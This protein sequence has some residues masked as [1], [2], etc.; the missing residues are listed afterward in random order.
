MRTRL[1][2]RGNSPVLVLLATFA[3][4]G[5]IKLVWTLT[6]MTYEWL[7]E[8]TGD[9]VLAWVGCGLGTFLFLACICGVAIQ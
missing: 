9:P 4:L 1:S 8:F 6:N 5:F 7:L 2:P 3:I